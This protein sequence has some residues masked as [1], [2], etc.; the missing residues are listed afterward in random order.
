MTSPQQG[1]LDVVPLGPLTNL[2]AVLTQEPALALR[3]T[4]VVAV[5]GSGQGHRLHPSENRATG[6]MLF[7][8]GPPFRDVNAV[9]DTQ[10]VL[11]VLASCVPVV[12][13][14]DGA[15][16]QIML[17]SSD[18]YRHGRIGQLKQP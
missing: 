11:V 9:L 16:R 17:T 14:P 2:P 4:C 1:P 3:L 12:F 8:Y 10:V 6:A 7:G 18:L 13:V 5:M 15:A